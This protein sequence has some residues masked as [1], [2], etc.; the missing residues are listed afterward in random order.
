MQQNTVVY[1]LLSPKPLVAANGAETWQMVAQ[2]PTI[3][4]AM[5]VAGEQRLTVFAIMC[6]VC[7]YAMDTEKLL[8]SGVV[9]NKTDA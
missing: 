4:D 5:R 2:T 7:V 6:A 8:L 1:H 9:T 3:D